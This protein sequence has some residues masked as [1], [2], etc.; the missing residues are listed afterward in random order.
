MTTTQE[1]GGGGGGKLVVNTAPSLASRLNQRADLLRRIFS[2]HKTRNPKHYINLRSSSKLF[3]R[4]LYQPP[5]LWTSYPNSNHATLQSLVDHLEEL[6][7]GE[8]SSGNVPS[9]IFIDEGEYNAEGSYVTLKKPLSMYGAGSGKT[10][11]VGVGL[12]IQGEKRDGIAEIENLT[13]K[14]GKEQG[15]N[16]WEGMNVIMRGCSIEECSSY[17]VVAYRAD[18]SCDDL[19]VVGCGESGVLACN[20]ATIT[21]SGQGTNIQEN[22]TK[23]YDF[24]F[25]LD[26][27]LNGL[28]ASYIHLLHP[29]T[30][31]QIS[32]DNGGGGNWGGDGTIEQVSK[33]TFK[34]PRSKTIKNN[35][36]IGQK[37]CCRWKSMRGAYYN[38]EIL[39]RN[40]DGTYVVDYEDGDK[41]VSVEWQRLHK[42]PN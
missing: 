27:S 40:E 14:G 10:T 8:E 6:R 11:L 20:N 34:K 7:G 28:D 5:P 42:D 18:I 3:H 30:K 1:D 9:V 25:G 16:A 29:L 2:F 24:S 36:C 31:E 19:Q 33:S 23:G 38:C 17:G 15:L 22:G 12:K 35:F 41:D 26:T 37:C 39:S 32:K 21:L 4:A 13:I